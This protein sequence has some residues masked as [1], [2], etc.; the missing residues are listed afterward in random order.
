MRTFELK[1]GRCVSLRRMVLSVVILMAVG[2]IALIVGAKWFVGSEFG[3]EYPTQCPAVPGDIFLNFVHEKP[4]VH[5]KPPPC[6][7]RRQ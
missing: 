5:D 1:L 7:R 3:R 2:G 4:P 6:V